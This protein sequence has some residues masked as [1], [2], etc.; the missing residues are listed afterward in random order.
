MEEAMMLKSFVL[1][2]R[3]LNKAINMNL[4]KIEFFRCFHCCSRLGAVVVSQYQKKSTVMKKQT[5][6]Q[7]I[8]LITSNRFSQQLG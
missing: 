1:K 7:E 4:S 3:M 5:V 6:Q 2:N 8:L